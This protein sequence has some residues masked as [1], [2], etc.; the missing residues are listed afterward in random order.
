MKK[1]VSIILG[2]SLLLMCLCACSDHTNTSANDTNE[3]NNNASVENLNGSD[4][5]IKVGFSH[6]S[7]QEYQ[8]ILLSYCDQYMAEA[9]IECLGQ[10][11]CNGDEAKHIQNIEVLVQQGADMVLVNADDVEVAATYVQAAKGTP[12]QFMAN[13][14][15]DE[16]MAMENVYYVGGDEEQAGV[17]C[18]EYAAKVL[19]E[20]G[21]TEIN[22]VVLQGTLGMHTTKVRTEGAIEGLKSA[23]LPINEV[24]VDT[25]LWTREG[26][27]EKLTPILSTGVDIDVVFCNNDD[28]ALGAVEA[29]KT[30]G[31]ND[32]VIVCGVDG[33]DTA[34]QAIKNGDLD[35]T[36]GLP[37]AQLAEQHIKVAKAVGSGEEIEHDIELEYIGISVENIDE[38]NEML[39]K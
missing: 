12:I 18:G 38:Y 34:L 37:P 10:L 25:A 7:I 28:M 3:T 35:F 2:V 11:N 17:I 1:L 31:L 9:G 6:P 8:A 20:Q 15:T 39:G 24:F 21:N 4:D 30:A 16:V 14:P 27:I 19:K 22:Y 13:R 29:L 36:A 26:A 33:M 5:V 32:E 23:G